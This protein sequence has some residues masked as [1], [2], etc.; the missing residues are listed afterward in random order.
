MK[1]IEKEAIIIIPA[2]GGSKRIKNKNLK[3]LSGKSLIEH[4]ILHALNSKFNS[5]IYV[6]TDSGSIKDICNKYPVNIVERPR[7]ISGDQASSE[8]ALLHTLD[9]L[10]K[11]NKYDP[12][13]VIFLQCSS[14]F[15]KK[16]DINNAYK[17]IISDNSDSL[18][19]VT[20]SK[21]FLWSENKRG[22]NK[23]INYDVKNRKREQD[24]KDTYE[25]NGSIYICKTKNLRKF[26]NRLSG[27]ISMYKMDF[28]SSL[29][30][31]EIHDFELANWIS[32]Y[33]IKNFKIP[34]LKDLEM[35]VFDFDGVF[36]N[37]KFSLNKKREEFVT[38]SRADGFAVGMLKHNKAHMLVLSSEENDVVKLRCQKLGI[39]CK[40][41]VDNK[42]KYLKHYFCKNG[43]NKENVLYIG[44]DLNDLECI[45]YVGFP[46]AVND[47]VD[48]VKKNSK[49]ILDS[50]GGDGA[51]R[52]LV[53]IIKGF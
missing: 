41:G 39:N 28:W 18:L 53:S 40:N 25:E 29:Q 15:R 50:K 22:T 20:E 51:I 2:R 42:I 3:L 52:E 16:N 33:K 26:N 48:L 38:L 30:I 36:T 45:K 31:D 23:A 11:K 47:A 43:I 13:Y 34:K 1:N 10:K 17:K 32:S 19:S 35:L 27:R 24:I 12:K 46:V 5:D 49:I 14:P 6:S 8:D 21:K 37:N 9:I 44:N 4:T 7:K